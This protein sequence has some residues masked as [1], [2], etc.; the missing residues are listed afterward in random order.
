MSSTK[1]SELEVKGCSSHAWID[2]VT[3][4]CVKKKFLARGRFLAMLRLTLLIL[5]LAGLASSL[6]VSSA[7]RQPALTRR[8]A[9]GAPRLA[10][11]VFMKSKEDREFEEWARQKKIASGVDPD[12][13]FGTGRRVESSIYLVGGLVTVLVPVIAGTWAYNAGYLT[14]Q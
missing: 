10:P 14:P 6:Q 4:V 13:D 3:S 2:V 9:V 12:E 7:L 1:H 5:A 8:S 11:D